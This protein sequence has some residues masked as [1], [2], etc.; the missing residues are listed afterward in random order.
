MPDN[1]DPIIFYSICAALGAEL[2][3][4]IVWCIALIRVRRAFLSVLIFSSLLSVTLVTVNVL[5]AYNPRIIVRLFTSRE[6]YEL[7]F[8]GFACVEAAT[9]L[10]DHPSTK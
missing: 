6:N 9:A 3:V 5:M 4:L 8:H 7:F 10:S 2:V 1:F